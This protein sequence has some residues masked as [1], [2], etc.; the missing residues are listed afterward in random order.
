MGRR[1]I[2][3]AVTIVAL[4]GLA[5]CSS[6]KKSSSPA[7]TTQPPAAATTA[8]PPAGGGAEVTIQN[9]SFSVPASVPVGTQITITN[10]DGFGHTFTDSGGAFSVS[11]SGGKSATLT[12]DKAGT[13]NVV[14]QIHPQMK[15]AL[16]VV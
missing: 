14:C 11:V 16:T 7:A 1:I 3:L 12:I 8:A 15:V 9:F 4:A 10:K 2:G 5:A 6:D 13:Y